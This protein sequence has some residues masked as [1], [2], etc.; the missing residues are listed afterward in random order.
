M[1]FKERK[2]IYLQLADY[3][4]LDILQEVYKEEERIPSVR[5]FAA[6]M[7]VNSNTAVRTYE[8]MQQKDIIY[9]RRGLGYFVKK[10]AKDIIRHMRRDEFLN[11]YLPELFRNMQ[12]LG[13]SMEEVE[14]E[15][16]KNNN[17]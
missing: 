8:W 6:Q 17:N 13:I 11:D 3:L 15:W 5:E 12:A 10:G 16:R 9:T 14:E 4:C 2:A 1:E 7:E